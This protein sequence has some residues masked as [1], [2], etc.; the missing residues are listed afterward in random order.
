MT[1]LSGSVLHSVGGLVVGLCC[2]EEMSCFPKSHRAVTEDPA[3]Y[4]MSIQKKMLKLLL[5]GRSCLENI[6]EVKTET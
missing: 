6:T 3:I 2:P 4:S 5:S 1:F